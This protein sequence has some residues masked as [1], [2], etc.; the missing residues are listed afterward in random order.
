MEYF[1]IRIEKN[2][3][4]LNSFNNAGL[5]WY[6]LGSRIGF[7][8]IQFFFNSLKDQKVDNPGAVG[9]FKE[10]LREYLEIEKI[11]GWFEKYAENLIINKE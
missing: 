3:P 5:F 11:E 9:K 10:V 2:N 1:L 8:N 4:K 7:D 6:E